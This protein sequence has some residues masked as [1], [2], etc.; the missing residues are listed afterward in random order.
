MCLNI[1]MATWE[2]PPNKVGG[3]AS[4]CYDLSRFLAGQ[5]HEVHVLTPYHEDLEEVVDGI[6]VHRIR[7]PVSTDL[8]S[9]STYISHK[10][11]KK[12]VQ[13]KNDYGIDVVHGHDWMMVPS[14]IAIK[15]LLSVPFV[16][17]IHSTERGRVGLHSR[18]SRM[19]NDLE[20]LGTYEAN[21]IITVGKDF[22]HEIKSMF[23]P[24]MEKLNYIPNGVDIKRFQKKPVVDRSDYV[25]DWEKM[26]LF[27]GRLTWQKGL[28]FFI[29]AMPKILE[30]HPEAKFVIAGKGDLDYYRRLSDALHLGPKVYFTGFV[31]DDVLVSLYKL[32]D[33]TVIPS[34]YEPFGIVALE[35]SASSTP[36][37]GS[38]TGGLKENIIHERTGLH[39]YPKHSQSIA[40]QVSRLLDSE[41]WSRH[42]AR[43]A[44]EFVEE[45]FNWKTISAWTA[46]VY[47]KAMYNY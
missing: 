36:P 8:I 13:I 24:P 43:N 34:I 14:S 23:N 22:M 18:F 7:A 44:K 41:S 42:L 4:H 16:F 17:T 37:V 45:D 28:E 35:S 40:D 25:A 9:W 20:W 21:K 12:A 3:I 38:Y 2:F 39:T 47:A 5:G 15:R 27:V 33:M 26:V 29:W 10:M 11:S 31:P 30:R 46:G 1:L 19:I 6:Y 32:A